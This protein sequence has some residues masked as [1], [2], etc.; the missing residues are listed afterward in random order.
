MAGFPAVEAESE[1]KVKRPAGN[2]TMNGFCRPAVKRGTDLGGFATA[3]GTPIS[4]VATSGFKK[5]SGVP[6]AASTG[7]EKASSVFSAPSANTGFKKPSGIPVA[8]GST[9][10]FKK[11]RIASASNGFK[12]PK[13]LDTRNP[14]V[15]CSEFKKPKLLATKTP[16][17]SRGRVTNDNDKPIN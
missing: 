4:A 2:V 13:R 6:V 10:G 17:Q 3:S 9:I 5:P 11:P 14:N 1:A 12:K 8:A 15:L 7:F 16:S